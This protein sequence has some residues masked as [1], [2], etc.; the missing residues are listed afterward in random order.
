[1]SVR[2]EP[3]DVLREWLCLTREEGTAIESACWI[4]VR[5]IQARKGAL[6]EILARIPRD[7]PVS[8][9]LRAEAGRILSLLSHHSQALATQRDKARARQQALDQAKQNVA[10]IRRSYLFPRKAAAWQ[11]Y[12]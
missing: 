6:R 3:A 4:E 12:S 9:A 1:M 8:A 11:S 2:I 7:Q 5:R 10:R